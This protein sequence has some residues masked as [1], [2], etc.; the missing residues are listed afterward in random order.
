MITKWSRM[1]T[2][3]RISKSSLCLWVKRF[4]WKFWRA[5]SISK[6]SCGDPELGSNSQTCL[7]TWLFN[8][9]SHGLPPSATLSFHIFK[10]TKCNKLLWLRGSIWKVHRQIELIVD[11]SNEM[12]I[13]NVLAVLGQIK[14]C[15]CMEGKPISTIINMWINE[16]RSGPVT[17]FLE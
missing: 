1:K 14:I 4:L 16:P 11:E 8:V 2:W 12:S 13:I 15:I 6:R 3:M 10:Q 9:R 17:S 5:V 7:P